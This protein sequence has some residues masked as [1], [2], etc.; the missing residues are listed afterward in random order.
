MRKRHLTLLSVLLIVG[1][2]AWVVYFRV[3]PSEGTIPMG[4]HDETIAWVALATA[5][6]TNVTA[7]VGLAREFL[8]ARRE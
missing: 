3:R 8:K 2:I 1:L 5:V 4:D 6:I 7:L